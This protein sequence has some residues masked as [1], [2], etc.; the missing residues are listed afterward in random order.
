MGRRSC[1]LYTGRLR[2]REDRLRRLLARKGLGGETLWHLFDQV[3]FTSDGHFG[4]D[5]RSAMYT[6]RTRQ[7]KKIRSARGAMRGRRLGV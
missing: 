7:S 1:V 2:F 4:S 6:H 3:T 5:A